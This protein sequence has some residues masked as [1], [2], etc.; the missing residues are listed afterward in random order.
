MITTSSLKTQTWKDLAD[1]A[2][3]KGL[4]GW[5]SMRKDELVKALVRSAK[6]KSRSRPKPAAPIKAKKVVRTT[7]RRATP[8][9]NGHAHLNGAKSNGAKSNG[10]KS[11]GA[12]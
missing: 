2:K 9:K 8:I 12:K 3:S 6:L 10:A 5:S 11:N 1:M 4:A 7:L